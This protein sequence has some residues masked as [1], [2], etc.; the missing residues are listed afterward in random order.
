MKK[1]GLVVVAMLLATGAYAGAKKSKA[2]DAKKSESAKSTVKGEGLLVPQDKLK[3]DAPYGP[4]GPQFAT[5]EGDQKKGPV[6]MFM[7]FPAG[8]D[9]GWHTHEGE[10]TAVVVQGHM[11]HQVQGGAEHKLAQ[12]SY[13]TQ[14]GKVNHKNVCLADG[15]ECVIFGWMPKGFSFTPKTA[16]GKDVPQE[17]SSGGK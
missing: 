6:S 12:G 10:Y 9:S 14:P 7:K 17:K 1:L 16:E 11:T 2:A 4:Q 3:W 8:F 15:G 5:A 13:W